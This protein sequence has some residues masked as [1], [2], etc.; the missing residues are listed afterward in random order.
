MKYTNDQE[1]ALESMLEWANRKVTSS[2]DLFYCLNGA[3]GT[4]KTTIAKA[5]IEQCGIKSIGVSAPTHKAKK[6]IS[7]STGLGAETIQKILGLRPDMSLETFDVNNIVFAQKEDPV[8]FEKK[9][10]IIDEASMLNAMLFKALCT[11]ANT[12]QVRLLFLGD[13]LQLRPVKDISVSPVFTK[14]QN[15]STLREICR[16]GDDNPMSDILVMLR[17][18]IE[19]G[20][21][22]GILAMTT[23]GSKVIGDNGF[24]CMLNTPSEKFGNELFLETLLLK[25]LSTEYTVDRDHIK[26]LAFTNET[27]V[28]Y[29]NHIRK[30]LLGHQANNIINEG[31]FLIGYGNVREG[32]KVKVVNSE[33]YQVVSVKPATS[34]FDI[35]GFEV[36]IETEYFFTTVFI[37]DH[38]NLK[39]LGRF[40][41][42]AMT[43]RKEAKAK[44]R[45][46]WRK[47]YEFKTKHLL[48]VDVPYNNN[49][50]PTGKNK[51]CDKDLYY[52]YGSTVHKSQGSTY[53]YSGIHLGDI[54]KCPDPSERARLV[55]VA[56][57]RCRHMNYLCIEQ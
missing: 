9:L 37:V 8:I 4:G 49:Y 56:L 33:E 6:V 28:H 35:E 32:N 30:A 27:V 25:Y 40:K 34:E 47:F 23:P 14:V 5:F 22:K 24:K 52:A 10:W 11:E 38:N 12:Y 41:S 46:Y 31:E 7:K 17:E 13:E 42:I 1:K 36:Q 45:Y 39:A 53:D 15:K 43:K 54:Y 16:Q 2:N 55:Y 18:D 3:A 51:F 19:R 21:D 50:P 57:S 44:G 48:L 20:T 29:S 26:F